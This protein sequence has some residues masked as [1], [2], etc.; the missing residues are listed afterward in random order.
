MS[1]GVE[2]MARGTK[3]KNGVGIDDLS[4]M[5]VK[6]AIPRNRGV[7]EKIAKDMGCSRRVIERYMNKNPTLKE[8]AAAEREGVKDLLESTAWRVALGKEDPEDDT[9]WIVK[10][11]PKMLQFLL[12]TFGQDR[13]YYDGPQFGQGNP[14]QTINITIGGSLAEA[15]KSLEVEAESVEVVQEIEASEAEAG[16]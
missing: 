12:K 15:D 9:K 7:Y 3:P 6:S 2:T 5:S 1:A 4:Y 11:D 10:P 8:E 14:N 13:G 16:E